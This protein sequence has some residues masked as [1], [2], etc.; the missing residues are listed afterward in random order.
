[1]SMATETGW[2]ARAEAGSTAGLKVIVRIARNLGR[3]TA[4]AV[5]VPIVLYFLI[6][7]GVERRASATFLARVTGRRTS[8]WQVFR[9]FLTF[10]RVAVD[11]VYLLTGATDKVPVRLHDEDK[12]RSLVRGSGGDELA[13]VGA[14]RPR[15]TGASDSKSRRWMSA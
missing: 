15:R 4:R 2:R 13:A 1:M 8:L 7:R 3:S 10:A 11:R 5:L 12:L 9:H 14:D 6:V